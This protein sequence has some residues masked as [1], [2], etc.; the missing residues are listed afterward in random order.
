MSDYVIQINDLV[1]TRSDMS[2]FYSHL[3]SI[4]QKSKGGK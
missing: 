4:E 2:Q 3:N 1:L